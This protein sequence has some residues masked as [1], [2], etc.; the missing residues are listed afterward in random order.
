MLL[1]AALLGVAAIWSPELRRLG[2]VLCAAVLFHGFCAYHLL[3]RELAD[4]GE[5]EGAAASNGTLADGWPLSS[6]GWGGSQ[7]WQ[8]AVTVIA[9]L[10]SAALCCWHRWRTHAVQLRNPEAVVDPERAKAE[11]RICLARGGLLISPCACRGTM[12]YVHQECV[13]RWALES[14]R[15]HCELCH[16]R[17]DLPAR[18]RWKLAAGTV[19]ALPNKIFRHP[20]RLVKSIALVP[21]AF[22]AWVVLSCG[23]AYL[24]DGTGPLHLAA[25]LSLDSTVPAMVWAG[26]HVDEAKGGGLVSG[27]LPGLGLPATAPGATPLF[28]AAHRGH[29]TTVSVLLSVGASANQAHGDGCAPLRI[30]AQLGHESVVSTLLSAGARVDHAEDGWLPLHAAASQG[31]ASVVSALLLAGARIERRVHGDSPLHSAANNGHESVVSLLVSA[32]ADVNESRQSGATP[33]FIAARNGHE[34][35]VSLLVSV[36]ADVNKGK[37]GGATPLFIAARNGHESVV[38]SLLSAG[39][40][41][42]QTNR[43]GSTP[44]FVAAQQGHDAVVHALLLAGASVNQ[45]TRSGATPLSIAVRSCHKSVMTV[46]VSAGALVNL[47]WEDRPRPLQTALQAAAQNCDE[48]MALALTLAGLSVG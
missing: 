37:E 9:G 25:Y 43:S 7:L 6:A 15:W 5:A 12:Q 30:A 36:G 3:Q 46:L 17:Y 22:A 33:L 44:L 38:Y 40:R 47:K 11:C 16:Q 27:L 19:R 28:I 24:Y 34:S 13:V 10:A 48:S 23:I 31:H 18:S 1:V 8:L 21:G 45:A 42:D 41:V 20:H 32:G 14:N 39:A 2:A 26:V 35:V 29:A 4:A